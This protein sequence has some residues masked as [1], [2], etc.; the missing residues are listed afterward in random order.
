MQSPIFA[1][2]SKLLRNYRSSSS[3]QELNSVS[4]SMEGCEALDSSCL[5]PL[6]KGPSLMSE[7]TDG[8]IASQ[9]NMESSYSL[10]R[11][12]DRGLAANEESLSCND[13]KSH[14]QVCPELQVE[15]EEHHGATLLNSKRPPQ[16][17]STSMRL[18]T[19]LSPL[20]ISP[21]QQPQSSFGRNASMSPSSVPLRNL[22]C[23]ELTFSDMRPHSPGEADEVSSLNL[24]KMALTPMN[25]LRTAATPTNNRVSPRTRSV[26]LPIMSSN[27]NSL[28]SPSSFYSISPCCSVS[29]LNNIH[30]HLSCNL[31]GS[32]ST[33]WCATTRSDDSAMTD[34]EVEDTVKQAIAVALEE[35]DVEAID[36]EE[37]VDVDEKSFPELLGAAIFENE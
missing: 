31:P 10:S 37:E 30:S 18:P 12:I 14:T 20:A 13:S 23:L 33:S 5:S 29:S 34:A 11:C 2:S 6:S 17:E 28:V 16:M 8:T 25:L 32:M 27:S 35:E 3:P 4:S 24:R 36:E 22:K 1:D 26:S 9:D 15:A 21:Y 7:R 19:M